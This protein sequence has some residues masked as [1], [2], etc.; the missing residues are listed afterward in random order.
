MTPP[1]VELQRTGARR[2]NRRRNLKM[3]L[4]R[5]AFRSAD[6]RFLQNSNCPPSSRDRVR[7]AVERAK[8]NAISRLV[9]HRGNSARG[10]G[11]GAPAGRSPPRWRKKP[12]ISSHALNMAAYKSPHVRLS[13]RRA[14][15]ANATATA[16]PS[17]HFTRAPFRDPRPSATSSSPLPVARPSPSLDRSVREGNKKKKERRIIAYS[18]SRRRARRRRRRRRRW[19][20]GRT[21]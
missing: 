11:R 16:S 2:R 5:D 19:S 13:G 21:D 10:R 7:R 6:S 8:H 20:D 14:A 4:A 3:E 1:S 17:T 9:N 15:N 12:R 18:L